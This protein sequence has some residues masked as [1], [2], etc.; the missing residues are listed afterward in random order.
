MISFKKA[1]LLVAIFAI[2]G[3]LFQG[4]NVMK[5][6]G[7]GI[8][9]EELNYTAIFITLFCSG[10]FVTLAT[11]YKVPI[12][13]SQ[14]IVGGIVGMGL[15]VG[16]DVDFSVF[17]LIA[18]SW[19]VCPIL[20]MTL[21]YVLSHLLGFVLRRL[22]FRPL[23]VQNTLGW[24]AI[25]SACYVSYSMGANNVGSAVG[26]ISNLGMVHPMVLLFIGGVGIA[27]GAATYGKKVS[28][29][30]GKGITPLDVS[31]AFVAQ[32][33]SAFGIHLFSVLGMPVSTSSAIVGSVVGVGLV[34]GTKAISK[35]TLLII[36]IGW[37]LSPCLAGLSS[38]ILYKGIIAA[39][40]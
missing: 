30:V 40:N 37:V 9:K 12:S 13:T 27:L 4:Q 17:A 6:I 18:E 39:F 8:V 28:D 32:F 35:K 25:I 14:A 21:S 15:A 36:F 16:A 10:F 5:T 1:V 31:G 29:T 33:S 38:F 7:K 26:P 34:K 3:A 19:I 22:A 11:F 2:I 23:L 24:M 20:I